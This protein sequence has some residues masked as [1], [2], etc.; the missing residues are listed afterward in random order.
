MEESTRVGGGS[1]I[2]TPNI[3]LTPTLGGAKSVS[4]KPN[5][6]LTGQGPPDKRTSSTIQSI[7]Q[8]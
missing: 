2:T 5:T 1:P 8:G 6:D 3:D 4:T 7:N